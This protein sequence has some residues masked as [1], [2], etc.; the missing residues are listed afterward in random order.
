MEL[1]GVCRKVL[2]I[3]KEKEGLWVG[4]FFSFPFIFIRSADL[5]RRNCLEAGREK[6]AVIAWVQ[7]KFH[8]FV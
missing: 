1:E 6:I 7:P 8:D 2:S 3:S 4:A 5:H